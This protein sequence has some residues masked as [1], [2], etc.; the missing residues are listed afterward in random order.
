M[1]REDQISCSR[2]GIFGHVKWMVF[3]EPE[4]IRVVIPWE[5]LD[6]DTVHFALEIID[7]IREW[8]YRSLAGTVRIV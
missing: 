7:K 5:D 8:M 6:E 3:I 4:A 1:V 2:K